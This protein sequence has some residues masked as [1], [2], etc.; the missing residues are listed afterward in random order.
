MFRHLTLYF[1]FTYMYRRYRITHWY[2]GSSIRTSEALAV[3][4]RD[5]VGLPRSD[6]QYVFW[7]KVIV[8]PL[9]H[10]NSNAAKTA[11]C[12]AIVQRT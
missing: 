7:T 4:K 11:F 8:L 12:K 5:S 1:T 6:K 9:R 2:I 10:A 3:M